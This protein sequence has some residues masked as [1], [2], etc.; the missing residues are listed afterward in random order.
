M[1]ATAQL[2]KAFTSPDCKKSLEVFE[3]DDVEV[4]IK[5]D[6]SYKRTIANFR[7]TGMLVGTYFKRIFQHYALEMESFTYNGKSVKIV[8]GKAGPMKV[9]AG[10]AAMFF[11]KF[12]KKEKM[13]L[14]LHLTEVVNK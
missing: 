12:V 9:D 10:T 1:V 11:V 6:S 3:P 5:S 7:A 8:G 4:Y 13:K 14:S 2:Y